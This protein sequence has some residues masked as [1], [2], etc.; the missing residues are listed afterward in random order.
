MKATPEQLD[1]AREEL[2]QLEALDPF[3]AHEAANVKIAA[4]QSAYNAKKAAIEESGVVAVRP[5]PINGL[6]IVVGPLRA[7]RAAL[8]AAFAERRQAEE[9]CRRVESLRRYLDT[10]STHAEFVCT[11]APKL[12]P[13]EAVARGGRAL[14]VDKATNRLVYERS[15]RAP[16]PTGRKAWEA[17]RAQRRAAGDQR[18]ADRRATIEANRRRRQGQD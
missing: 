16:V 4:A 8:D 18:D 5:N 1:A 3:A 6:P 11:E 12:T 13:A 9:L 7:L 10:G 17:E 2:A 15:E 14:V